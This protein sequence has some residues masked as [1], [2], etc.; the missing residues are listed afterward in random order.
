[1]EL[2]LDNYIYMYIDIFIPETLCVL[3]PFPTPIKPGQW[4]IYI[5]IFIHL[6]IYVYIKNSL[7]IFAIYKYIIVCSCCFLC[8]DGCTFLNVARTG[9]VLSREITT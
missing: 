1:M 4:V 6:H 7:A 8:T 5:Y 3:F 2:Y 9:D